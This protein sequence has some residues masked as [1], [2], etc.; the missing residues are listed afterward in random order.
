LSTANLVRKLLPLFLLAGLP[1]A[2]AW[3]LAADVAAQAA[4]S[5]VAPA[6]LAD[7]LDQRY[8]VPLRSGELTTRSR[9][10][11][12]VFM[13]FTSTFL[14]R[15][16]QLAERLTS[17]HGDE[18]TL[19]FRHV[20]VLDPTGSWKAARA[21]EAARLQGRFPAFLRAIAQRPIGDDQSPEHLSAA[22]GADPTRFRRDFASPEVEAR[23]RDDRQLAEKLGLLAVPTLLINGRLAPD[24]DEKQIGQL[25][26]S[27]LARVKAAGLPGGSGTYERLTRDGVS[28]LVETPATV[29][30]VAASGLDKEQ[31]LIAGPTSQVRGWQF[32]YR[33]GTRA[34]GKR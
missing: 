4:G 7:R 33:I 20:P 5:N 11:V 16:A 6:S 1:A 23:I 10:V 31:A 15:T 25:V 27:E 34:R 12:I 32:P 26:E 21:A 13:D 9:V 22:I 30:G 2:P 28:R 19:V 14:Q 3:T 17:R 24:L 29:S 18:V 8:R